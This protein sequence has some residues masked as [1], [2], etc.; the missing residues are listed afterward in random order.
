MPESPLLGGNVTNDADFHGGLSSVAAW[1]RWKMELS[2]VANKL[3]TPAPY[4]GHS[5]QLKQSQI[6][7]RLIEIAAVCNKNV[8][9]ILSRVLPNLLAFVGHNQ[10]FAIL[11]EAGPCPPRLQF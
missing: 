10:G 6:F 5:G 7:K 1:L 8:V 4:V 9:R 11:G 2:S 3:R